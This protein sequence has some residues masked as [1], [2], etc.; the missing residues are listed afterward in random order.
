MT[1]LSAVFGM[2]FIQFLPPYVTRWVSVLLFVL[3]GL[4]MLHEGWNM[5][6]TGAAEEME[7]VQSDIR[8]RE[9]EVSWPSIASNRMLFRL[10][11]V[12]SIPFHEPNQ[13]KNLY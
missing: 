4:K 9:D 12:H 11:F 3:F 13:M 10:D 1:V 8:K 6:A 7:E 2:V 5:T